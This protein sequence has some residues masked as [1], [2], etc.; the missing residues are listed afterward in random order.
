VAAVA[1][2]VAVAAA[3][4]AYKYDSPHAFLPICCVYCQTELMEAQTR[5]EELMDGG[6]DGATG[7]GTAA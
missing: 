6:A 5:L 2:T 1:V 3:R 4:H 7:V